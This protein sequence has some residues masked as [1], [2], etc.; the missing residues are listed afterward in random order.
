MTTPRIECD[1]AAGRSLP[2]VAFIRTKPCRHPAE[3]KFGVQH[4]NIVQSCL[5]G[6]LLS[7]MPFAGALDLT[8][9]LDSAESG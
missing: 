7:A 2:T 3:L 4:C 5:A 8:L 6:R 1:V 9:P